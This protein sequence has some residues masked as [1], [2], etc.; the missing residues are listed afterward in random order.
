[1]ISH[2]EISQSSYKQAVIS[3]QLPGEEQY[4]RRQLDGEWVK[5]T[6]PYPREKSQDQVH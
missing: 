2:R 5:S 3:A 6:F 4:W 1:M